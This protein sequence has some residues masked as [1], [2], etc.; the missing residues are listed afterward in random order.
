MPAALTKE[1]KMER[2]ENKV[3]L[4]TGAG[5]L[6]MAVGK[7]ILAEGGTVSFI[8]Y[9]TKALAEAGEEM[10]KAGYP[11]A[12]VLTIPCDV[13]RQSECDAA[14]QKTEA[15]FGK[16]DTMIA[17]A[18]II[19]HKPIDELTDEDWQSV[20][21]INLTGVFHCC[22]AVVPGMK[23]RKYGHIVIIS[24]VGGRTGRACGC[25]YAASKAGVNGLAINLG[26][27]LAKWNITVNT[28]APGPL[29]G[30]M[31]SSMPQ[32]QQDTLAKGIPLG[33]VG[34]LDD[35]AAA[36]AFLG[37]DDASWVTGEVL[38]CNGGIQY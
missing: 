31:F 1:E 24:S 32:S 37:S 35:A 27:N 16:I 10:K 30:R 25:N 22:K 18:G 33:R 12:R 5:D 3:V 6:A 11:E 38:D 21:D 17:T 36:A 4:I 9:S 2:Y 26:Y 7:R 23:E 28:V 29:K 20:I 34:E 8:D 19:R 14:V 15:A 13:T